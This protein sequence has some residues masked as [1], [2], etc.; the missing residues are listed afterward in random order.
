MIKLKSITILALIFLSGTVVAQS[1]LDRYN[2]SLELYN[3]EEY[4]KSLATGEEALI[5]YKRE[6][7]I[8]HSNYMA[9]LRQLSVNAYIVNDLNKAKGYAQT[10]VDSWR[11]ASRV[12][13]NIFVDALDN[14]GVMLT[15]TQEYDQ[16]VSVLKEAFDLVSLS[17]DKS[18]IE[19]AVIEGHLA[20]A[21]FASGE[22]Q[23]SKTHFDSVLTILD[24]ADEV[25]G[26][27][28]NFTYSYGTLLVDLKDYETGRQYLEN[29]FQWY[30]ET[31][32]SPIVVNTNL[33]LGTAYTYLNQ[34]GS[35]EKYYLLALEAVQSTPENYNIS[36]IE[37]KQKLAYNYEQQGRSEEAQVLMAEIS[38]TV[39]SSSNGSA[40]EQAMFLNNQATSSLNAGKID[41]ALGFYDE[42]LRILETNKVEVDQNYTMILLNAIRANQQAGNLVKATEIASAAVKNYELAG[43]NKFQLMTEYAGLLQEQGQF[44][45]ASEYFELVISGDRSA[46]PSITTAKILNKAATYYQVKGDFERSATL[47]LEALGQKGI[48]TDKALYQSLLF[49]YMTLLQAQG[50]LVEAQ[51]LMDDLKTSIGDNDPE[52]YL[53]LLRNI[54]TLAQSR[55]DFRTASRRFTE[56]LDLAKQLYGERSPEYADILLRIATLDKNLGNYQEAEPKF[57]FVSEIIAEAQ[58][59]NHPNYASVANNMGILYQ[60]MGNYEKAQEKFNQ[61]V[62]IY[63]NAYGEG[64]PDYVLS[65]ENLAT[66]YELKGEE[67]K[68]L[69]ILAITLQA[70]K[71]IYGETNPNY[72]VSLHN[73]ASLLQKTDRKDEAFAMLEKVLELQANSMGTLQPGYAN[74][75]HNL[76][77]LAQEQEKYDLA[78]SLIDQVLLIRGT[79]FDVYHPAYNSALYSKAVL[80]QVTNKYDVAW[81]TYNEVI[82]QYLYQIRKYFPSLSEVEKNAFYAKLAPVVNRYKEFCI[83][84][85][86]NY[87]QDPEI[88]RKL[89]TVQLATK[90][91]LLNAVN[92]TREIIMN[93]GNEEIIAEFNTWTNLKKQLVNY[94]SYSKEQLIAEGI[95]IA[96]LEEEANAI[97]KS[98]SRQS[99]AFAGE[100]EQVEITWQT[101]AQKLR[102]DEMAVELIR[103][104]RNGIE[105]SIT[106]AGLVL[107]Q[108]SQSPS[109]VTMPFGASMESKYYN[110]YKNTVKYRVHDK[111]S[112]EVFW[113][114]INDLIQGAKTIYISADGVYNKVNI[115]TIFNVNTNN[116]LIEDYFVKYISSTKDLLNR[117]Q[118]NTENSRSILCMGDPAYDLQGDASRPAQLNEVQRSQLNM[119]QISPL[120]GTKREINYIDSLLQ[121]NSWRVQAFTGSDALEAQLK[122]AKSANVIHLATHGFFMPD[123]KIS[124]IE[125]QAGLNDF[126][127]NPLFRSG[128]LFAGASNQQNEVENDGVLTAYEAMNLY[129]DNT[130]LVV[131]SACETA[132]GDVKNGEGV[133]GL[134]RALVVAGAQNLIMSLWKVND[135]ATMELMQLFYSNWTSG[136]NVYQALQK[137]QIQM[138]KTHEEPYFWGGFIMIGI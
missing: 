2:E 53:G 97:E 123:L 61:A 8:N 69:E 113:Q 128:L 67:E 37:L 134:Q 124:E 25:P 118:A 9:I 56:A 135:E 10:E 74:S 48:E 136:N 127:R 55:G 76:A 131:L 132:L 108:N 42:A 41:E 58:G 88:L 30:E 5:Q 49:N 104:E 45:T 99:T 39:L 110:F 117:R 64:N 79:L 96:T 121:Q 43:I 86:I 107:H 13:E 28:L 116:Y 77:I 72:A 81:I 33:G 57:L 68:A 112:Y 71:T 70:N 22:L 38:T 78:D 60:Q 14:L 115:N 59:V 130:E 51:V 83:E 129:L 92:K 1:W 100:F 125:S 90:A 85:Y 65:L 27:Y 73:Y 94:Y 91:L 19:K 122:Q 11:T 6:G 29:I 36:E 52:I 16:A 114:P 26:D 84:Y 126:D 101:V 7:D 18:T 119:K 109:L 15:V 21:Y 54:G 93:S 80:L 24:Q 31:D 111:L 75:L 47:Y 32:T 103:I 20:E 35:G 82:E 138:M 106:Y 133:Y 50:K 34:L 17:A 62:E 66:L 4:V 3:Q 23:E 40:S 12:D 89:Y 44:E 95:N 46:W 120:P 102:T 137:A 98:L 63:K 105:D 87:K